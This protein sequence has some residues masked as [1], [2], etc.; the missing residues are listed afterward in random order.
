MF[1]LSLIF[2]T[3]CVSIK[4]VGVRLPAHHFLGWSSGVLCGASAT[5]L[6]CGCLL[7]TSI[8][9]TIKCNL[10]IVDLYYF[11]KYAKYY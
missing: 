8:Y 7:L 1:I 6:C 10:S 3:F 2:S 9:Y 5:F 4:V 11:M